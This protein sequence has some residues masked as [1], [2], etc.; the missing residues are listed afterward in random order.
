MKD[1]RPLLWHRLLA[2]LDD[3]LPMPPDQR[4]EREDDGRDRSPE[5]RQWLK[6]HML[7]KRGKGGTR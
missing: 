4:R 3:L 2:I 5:R 7:S 1:R 6:F